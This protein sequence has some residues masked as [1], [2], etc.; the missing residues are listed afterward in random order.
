VFEA[1]VHPPNKRKVLTRGRLLVT[2][3]NIT[4]SLLLLPLLLQR[5]KHDGKKADSENDDFWQMDYHH[6]A[7]LYFDLAADR[8][9]LLG[10]V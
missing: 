4:S 10:F 8:W 9:N 3:A 6:I 5:G 7:G 1:K 2:L